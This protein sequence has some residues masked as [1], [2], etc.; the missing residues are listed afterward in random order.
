MPT[1]SSAGI[2]AAEIAKVVEAVFATMLVLE[3]RECELPWFPNGE[4]L[5]AVL[6]MAGEWNGVVLLE[7]DRPQACHFASRFLSI[8]QPSAVDDDVRDVLGELVNMIGGNMKCLFAPGIQLSMPS[9]VDGSDY[10][11]RVCGAVLRERIAFQSAEGP[12][13]VAILSTRS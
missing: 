4:H 10:C 1:E 2:P 13:W 7:C 8:D 5:T 6:H 3:V 11:L 12:I 9:V